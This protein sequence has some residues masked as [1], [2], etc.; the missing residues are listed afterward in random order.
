MAKRK[1]RLTD[2]QANELLQVYSSCKD[3][4]TRTRYQAVRLYGIGYGCTQVQEITGCSRSS[5]MSWCR[6]YREHGTQGLIDK[7]VGGNRARLTQEQ[8][9]DLRERLRLYKPCDLFGDRAYLP[10]GQ[11]WTVA[12]LHRAVKQWYDVEYRTRTSYY[13]LFSLCEFSYQRPA[14]VFKS[15]SQAKVGDFEEMLEKN[16]WT[17]P[18]MRPIP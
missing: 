16:S 17:S 5:L 9:A 14:K 10:Q 2:D 1:F 7:R 12:D 4:P 8:I 3:G 15:R 6:C 18:K 11:F 13:G